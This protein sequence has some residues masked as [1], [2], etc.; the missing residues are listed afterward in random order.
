[1]CYENKEC[2]RG[3]FAVVGYVHEHSAHVRPHLGA[4]VSSAGHATFPLEAT[5]FC[6]GK[7]QH[8]GGI[9]L[10]AV[11][12]VERRRGPT[13]GV[14]TLANEASNTMGRGLGRRTLYLPLLRN[15]LY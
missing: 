4:L 9:F 3:G 8:I 13:H 10:G 2:P 15:N 12:I 6:H 5:S 11:A 1:M 7:F 14:V